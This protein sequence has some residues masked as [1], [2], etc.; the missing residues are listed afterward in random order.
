MPILGHGALGNTNKINS[1]DVL[2]MLGWPECIGLA[3]WNI[4]VASIPV[5]GVRRLTEAAWGRK[6]VLGGHFGGVP[7]PL[8]NASAALGIYSEHEAMSAEEALDRL[9]LGV[10][11]QA[12]EGSAG[13]DLR[14]VVKAITERKADSRHFSF[15]TDEQEADSLVLDGHVDHKI[16][17]AIC[18]GID[19]LTAIQMATINA[20]EYFRISDDMGS[21]GP[22]KIAD[23]VLVD[24]LAQFTVTQVI[25]NGKVVARDGRYVGQLMAPAYP[26]YFFNTVKIARMTV[27]EDFAVQA[28]TSAGGRVKV[29]V[30]GVNEGSLITEDR[31]LD[32][33]VSEGKVEQDAAQDVMKIAVLDRHEASGRIGKAFVQGFR[34]K[35]GAIGSSFNPGQMNLMVAGTNDRDMS[36]V[37]NRIAET[38]RRVRCG[39]RRQDTGRAASALARSLR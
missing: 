2:D 34:I 17:T 35:A 25:A 27:P 14:Q 7:A 10:N 6:M 33:P 26:D 12:R 13:R 31:L 4:F 20:A 11:I 9:R 1:D 21:I 24:D 18:C 38:R 16:R 36:L 29:R 22:G 28:P 23:L 30:I 37:A 32:L 8:A 5:P 15:S 3:E 19:P 39:A